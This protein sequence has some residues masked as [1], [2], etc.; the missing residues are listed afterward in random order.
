M[1]SSGSIDA[2]ECVFLY[3][4]YFIDVNGIPDDVVLCEENFPFPRN[5]YSDHGFFPS[6]PKILILFLIFFTQEEA[7]PMAET[8][9]KKQAKSG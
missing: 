8:K 1:V 5:C 4:N 3:F 7:K 6:F 9:T 2:L